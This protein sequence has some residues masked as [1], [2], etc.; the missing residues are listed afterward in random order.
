MCTSGTDLIFKDSFTLD[1]GIP[2]LLPSFPDQDC[3]EKSIIYF[4]V[5][6][7]LKINRLDVLDDMLLWD[8]LNCIPWPR[9]AR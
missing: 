6:Q 3:L 7:V 2:S 5:C 4:S 1:I 8:M 9:L